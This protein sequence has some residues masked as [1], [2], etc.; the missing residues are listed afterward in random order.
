MRSL[1]VL[2]LA[3]L[4]S[5]AQAQHRVDFTLDLSAEIAAG[6]LDPA[7]DQV[8]LRGGVAPLDWGRTLPAHAIDH[9]RYAVSVDFA[10]DATHGQPLPYKIKID[11]PGAGADEGWESGGNRTLMLVG[12]TQRLERAFNSDVQAPP[13]SRVGTIERLAPLPSRFVSARGVQVWLPP[14]YAELAG[15]P[16]PVLYLHDGQ[17]VF[18]AAAAGAE[19]Q[20]DEA[21][22]VGV[23][24][25]RL[26][27]FI[28]VAVDSTAER[29]SD[30]TPTSIWLSAERLGKPEGARVGGGAANYA[31]YLIEELKPYIDSHYRTQADAAHTAVGGSSLGGLMSLWL[32]LHHPDVFGAALVV[33]PSVWWDD[34][35]A[36]REVAASRWHG[37]A[38]PRLWL[39]M[40]GREGPGAL[41]AARKLRDALQTQ[42]WSAKNLRYVE[43]PEGTH[44]EASWAQRVPGMLGFLYGK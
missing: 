18:D 25:R 22:Q 2:L 4:G 3:L 17:N 34:Q 36:L 44:T 35:L 43:A 20:V 6:R 12:K 33:S 37:A 13:L 30:Y 16:Y 32:A 21:A 40:G 8:G 19:W 23:T 28:V 27:P 15:R 24:S 11:R 39:D 38:R 9:G 26:A 1:L 14:G 29:M 42:G 7:R 10:E 31:R 5:S 41:E